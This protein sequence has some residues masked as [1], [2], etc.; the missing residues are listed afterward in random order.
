GMIATFADGE[1]IDPDPIRSTGVAAGV[2]AVINLVRALD[3]IEGEIDKDTVMAKMKAA[4]GVPL[5]LAEGQ[6]FTCDGTVI[7]IMP[8]VCSAG[9]FIGTLT[10]E[11]EVQNPTPVDATALFEMGG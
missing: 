3:G 5:F 1:D 10:A 7:P 6:T 11:A 9:F 2:G 8:S 4:A